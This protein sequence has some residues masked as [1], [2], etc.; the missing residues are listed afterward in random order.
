MTGSW[1]DKVGSEQ[2]RKWRFGPFGW[3]HG[4]STVVSGRT[5]VLSTTIPHSK[6]KFEEQ[7]GLH[8]VENS[9]YGNST[10]SF[11]RNLA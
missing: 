3:C 7:L 4:P 10:L 9:I 8:C 11:L 6:Y 2:I 1:V 5:D